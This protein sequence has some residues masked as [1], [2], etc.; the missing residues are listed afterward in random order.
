MLEGTWVTEEVKL[1]IEHGYKIDKIFSVWHCSKTEQY[2]PET[3]TG[4][5]FT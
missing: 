3:K 2:D 5:L 1:A 4:G